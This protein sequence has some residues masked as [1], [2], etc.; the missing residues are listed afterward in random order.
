MNEE[1]EQKDQNKQTEKDESEFSA[2]G[3]SCPVC[4]AT[5]KVAVQ[6]Q[7]GRRIIRCPACKGRGYLRASRAGRA[8]LNRLLRKRLKLKGNRCSRRL[9]KLFASPRGIWGHGWPEDG[10]APELEPISGAPYFDIDQNVI[11]SKFK[12]KL[13]SGIT[14]DLS[15][16]ITIT[17]EKELQLAEVVL[18]DI[19]TEINFPDVPPSPDD[20]SLW[21]N[22]LASY[23]RQ[24]EEYR[25]M[26]KH[27]IWGPVPPFIAQPPEGYSSYGIDSLSVE[28]GQAETLPSDPTLMLD[29]PD[30]DSGAAPGLNLQPPDTQVAG[31]GFTS[32]LPPGMP[33][34]PNS[35]DITGVPDPI[36]FDINTD[37]IG[38]PW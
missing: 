9:Q 10:I 11:K 6:D 4:E 33:P 12:E 37:I 2:A 28:L 24:S 23:D 34:V 27:H 30:A 3:V 5:G 8:W 29:T 16:G 35:L 1:P 18:D 13:F 22:L 15:D 19:L 21:P 25:E 17:I 32:I 31:L 36:G 26:F 7:N 20:P 14:L 38:M